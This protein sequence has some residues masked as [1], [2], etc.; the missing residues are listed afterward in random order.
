[1]VAYLAMPRNIILVVYSIS[2]TDPIFATQRRIMEVLAMY[3]EKLSVISLN[4]DTVVDSI[5]DNVSVKYVSG[6]KLTRP[7]T[8]LNCFFRSL[9][10]KHRN[11]LF[12]H[13]TEIAS[14]ELG[15]LTRI[16]RIKHVLW[17]AHSNFSSWLR[18]SSLLVDN[19]LTSTPGSCPYKGKKL[20]IIGQ[21]VDSTLYHPN[22]RQGHRAFER[23]IHV[24]RLDPSKGIHILIETLRLYRKIQP[25]ATLTLVGAETKGNTS[26]VQGLIDSNQDLIK[27]GVLSLTGALSPKESLV[28]M[29]NCDVFVHAF[30]GSL[31]KSL[32]EATLVSIPVVTCNQE[33]WNALAEQCPREQIRECSPRS[34]LLQ[35]LDYS[36]MKPEALNSLLNQRRKRAIES[37]SLTQWSHK[38]IEVLNK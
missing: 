14:A 25:N 19:I 23:L 13:M 16:L 3:F 31:D 17:Y 9:R 15:F 6:N 35:I 37:H 32:V 28:Q 38:V 5:P 29:Q 12:S 8:L 1:M 21:G 10:Y 30:V 27:A 33:Y 20:N 7:F 22:P 2:S 36:S 4:P 26:Y 18:I 11:I 34:L 24:G